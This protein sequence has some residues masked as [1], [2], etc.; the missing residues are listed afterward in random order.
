MIDIE[1]VKLEIVKSLKPLNPLKI[2]LFGS[3]AYGT[4]TEDSDIDLYVVTNDDFIP[5]TWKEKMKIKLKFSKALRDLKQNYDIDLITHTKKM[6]EK[7][8]NLDSMFSRE[9]LAKGKVIYG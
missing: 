6:S 2:I 7:F 3:Y 5:A 9:I 8:A 1:K 4:P